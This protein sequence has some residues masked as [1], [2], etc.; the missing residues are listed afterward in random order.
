[1]FSRE[2]ILEVTIPTESDMEITVDALPVKEAA[3][4]LGYS[5]QH[6]RRLVREGVLP[7][8]KIGRDWIVGRVG[9]GRLLSDR[10]NLELPL[11]KDSGRSKKSGIPIVSLFCGSG[12]LDLGFVQEGF[13]PLVAFDHNASALRTY[14][15]NHCPREPGRA[16]DADLSDPRP[17]L[18]S[19]ALDEI[20]ELRTPRGVIGG[21][22]CQ[23]FSASNV[24]KTVDDPRAKLPESY[25]AI[26]SSLNREHKI[27]F[28]VFENVIGLKHKQHEQLFGYFKELFMR[29]GFNIFEGQLD[30]QDFG[31]PQ[32]RKRV[33][34]VGLNADKYND[35]SFRFPQ[36]TTPRTR[37]TV[38]DAI[39]HLPE[40]VF[41]ERGLQ[42][43][44]IPLHANHWAMKPKSAKFGNGFLKEGNVKGR[45][46]RVLSWDQP[47]WTVAYG[48]REVH[49]HPTGKRRLSVYEAMLL[50]GFPPTYVLEG[51]LSDQIRQVSDAV[52]P[53][54]ARAL[55]RAIKNT[56][57]NT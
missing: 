29:A 19:N 43:S 6:T 45:P 35:V 13:A 36:T 8:G 57:D 10:A 33:F 23:A 25:S 5:V 4:L 42:P 3:R 41:F 48:H 11:G 7:G 31:V 38:R 21:P 20:N 46:F 51:T 47:S 49:I 12:G 26:L 34:V 14:R 22:P 56:I 15:K 1:M 30:A 2:Q 27:D 17:N 54:V 52:A 24:Y 39:A 55:A 18:V 9:L 16:I 53:P 40:P 44:E 37:R 28:F 32:E 50:Q